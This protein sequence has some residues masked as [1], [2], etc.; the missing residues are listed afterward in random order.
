VFANLV[1]LSDGFIGNR[2]E[3]VGSC[4]GVCRGGRHG[5]LL[6]LISVWL[7]GWQV[8]DAPAFEEFFPGGL[9][10]LGGIC[11]VLVVHVEAEG[12]VERFFPHL[13][14]GSHRVHLLNLQ[15]E[16]DTRTAAATRSRAPTSTG[17]RARCRIGRLAA[18]AGDDRRHLAAA[19][20]Y[21][22]GGFG[23]GFVDDLIAFGSGAHLF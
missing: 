6:L 12:C 7:F 15:L 18:T 8:V 21:N 1:E 13:E 22:F 5:L 3:V 14:N 17:T 19:T 9:F 16:L 2:G 4:V 20:D 10:R 11:T 23:D